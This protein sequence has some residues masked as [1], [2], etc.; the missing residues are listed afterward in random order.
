MANG[1]D[2][3]RA[4]DYA[5]S[6]RDAAR[7]TEDIRQNLQEILFLSRDYA[8][9]AREAANSIFENNIQAGATAKAFRDLTETTRDIRREFEDIVGGTKSMADIAKDL[10]KLETRRKNLLV[11]Q[12]Q[13]L[14]AIFTENAFGIEAQDAINQAMGSTAGLQDV[15]LEYGRDLTEDQQNLLNLYIEQGLALQDQDKDLE[16]IAKRAET[17]DS[18]M[19][20]FGDRAIG[21]QDAAKGLS[22]G[23]GKAGFGNLASKMGIDEAITGTREMASSLTEGGTKAMGMSGKMKLAGNFAK[24]LGSNLMASLGPAALLAMAIEQIVKA[25]KLIDSQSGEVAKSMGISAEE[26]R[27]LVSSSADAAAMSGDLLTSTKDVVAAQMQLNKAFGTSVQFSGEFA[28]EFASIQERTGLSAHTMEVFAKKALI[29][30]TSIEDQLKKVTAVTM[31]LSAQSGVMLNA[32]DIQEGIG[33]MSAAQLLTAKMNTKEMAN[34]VFQTKLLGISQSQLE[35]IGQSLLDFESSIASE[36]EA[37]LLTGKELNLDR[38]R[39]A[40][41]QGDQATLAAEL[42]KEVGT[43]AEFGEMNVIAQEALAKSFGMQREDMAKMLV[44]QEKLEAVKAAGFKSVSEAQD[45]YNKA[46]AEGTLTEEKKEKLQKAGLLNQMESA[47]QQEKLNAAMEKITDLFVQIIDPLMPII[48][49]IMAVL[50]PIFAILSPILK[51]IG[52]L[53]SLIMGA[54]TPALKAIGLQFQG[55]ADFWTGVFNL[56]FDMMITG[57]RKIGKSILDFVLSPFEAAIGLL[58]KIP[59]VDIPTVGSFTSN[60]VGLAE[61]GVVTKPTT[62]L[63]GE[64]GEPEAVVPLSKA[65]EMGFGSSEEIKQTNALLKEL[66]S[67]VKQGGNVYMD[68][69]KVGTAMAVGTYKVQ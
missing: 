20:P 68:S 14:S 64:G 22:E 39:A 44:E 16:E 28:A 54:L 57:L 3:D 13:A 8:K 34:Q 15:L 63:I 35:G 29:A 45:M 59:G 21:L 36:M 51:L 69:T 31:E 12:E 4:R 58:N 11:E 47:T 50:D 42:R 66:I 41:L 23:L 19:R 46:L 32:K 18:A 55:I 37:E 56:D 40:A 49:A 24:T 10:I 61:G 7:S 43:A 1:L 30:G 27:S 62:A 6:T 5:N 25:F 60:L 33:E 17:I 65:Q 38:A 48:D 26:G 52:D 9:E 2:P 67:A 53:N